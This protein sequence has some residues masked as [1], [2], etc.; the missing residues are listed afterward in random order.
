MN[1]NGALVVHSYPG[2]LPDA[3]YAVEGLHPL[4]YTLAVDE[5]YS[6]Y[7]A[8]INTE[9]GDP[10]SPR[11]TPRLRQYYHVAALIPYFDENGFFKIV[12]FESAAETSF[13]AFRNR[14]PGHHV[15]LVKIPV[16]PTFDP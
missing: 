9:L 4:L 12:V 7:L 16:S 3:G 1:D 8:A 5:P 2:F 10:T 13:T 15:N 11:G 6:F 14:Y